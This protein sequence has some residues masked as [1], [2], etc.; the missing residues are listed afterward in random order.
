MNGY[1]SFNAGSPRVK[2]F[3]YWSVPELFFAILIISPRLMV[4]PDSITVKCTTENIPVQKIVRSRIIQPWWLTSVQ[5]LLRLYSEVPFLRQM[6]C[7][8]LFW[9]AILISISS[10]LLNSHVAVIKS[11]SLPPFFHEC[12][13]F[14]FYNSFT[15]KACFIS[16]SGIIKNQTS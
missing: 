14:R 5:L 15:G 2:N 9:S 6:V 7:L 8:S 12:D 3:F 10:N 16:M 1:A 13:I 4:F 11:G